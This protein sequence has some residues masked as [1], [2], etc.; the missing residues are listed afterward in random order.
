MRIPF[1]WISVLSCVLYD[2]V[3]AIDL[4][5]DDTNSII[6]AAKIVAADLT[7]FWN[8]FTVNGLPPPYYW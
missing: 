7:A 1:A 2:A 6:N 8:P 3:N 5:T 4:N